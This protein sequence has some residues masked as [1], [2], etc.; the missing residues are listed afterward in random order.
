M[1][2]CSAGDVAVALD[3]DRLRYDGTMISSAGAIALAGDGRPMAETPSLTVRTGRMDSLD[4]G[5]LLNRPGLATRLNGTLTASAEGTAPD[6]MRARLLLELLPSRV[7]QEEIR[8]GR[9]DLTLDRGAL[10]GDVRMDAADGELDTR[11]QGSSAGGQH[12]IKRGR[13]RYG[14][15]DSIAGPASARGLADWPAGSRSRALPTARGSPVSRERS[16]RMGRVDSVAARHAAAS[17]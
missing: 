14:W 15:S 10:R 3:G 7:N 16:P 5:A 4:L 2:K 1:S 13:E 9:A 8:S 12:R 6:S 17:R 11:V